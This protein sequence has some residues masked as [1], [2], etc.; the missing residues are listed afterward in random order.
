VWVARLAG[1]EGDVAG[2][3]AGFACAAVANVT[4]DHQDCDGLQSRHHLDNLEILD[5]LEFLELADTVD[6]CVSVAA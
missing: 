2:D 3:D 5:N 4:R 6:P 1:E